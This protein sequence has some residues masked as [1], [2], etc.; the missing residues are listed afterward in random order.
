MEVS[1]IVLKGLK[2]IKNEKEKKIGVY[3]VSEISSCIRR[4]YYSYFEETEYSYSSYKFFAIGNALHELIQKILSKSVTDNE[5]IKERNEVSHKYK[6]KD[7][8]IHGRLDSIVTDKDKNKYIIEIKT[9][10]NLNFSP[11]TEHTEQLN[12]YLHSYPKAIGYLL[13]L[14]TAKKRFGSDNYIEMKEYKIEYNT[15]LFNESVKKIERLH[16]ALT[17]KE[18][19]E[20]ESKNDKDKKWHCLVC[21]SSFKERCDL[22]KNAKGV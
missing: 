20:A 7:F 13:Y 10:S 9:T 12:F 6:G 8:E 19:P 22:N 16:Q 1:N 14:N 18:L 17:N 3:Y 4:N 15:N 11:S 21:P 2:Y 5:W